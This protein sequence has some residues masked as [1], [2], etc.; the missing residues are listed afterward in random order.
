MACLPPW[1]TDLWGVDRPTMAER[2]ACRAAVRALGAV[3]GR[4]P[5]VQAATERVSASV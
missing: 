2:S 1:A 5:G 3:L 4:P